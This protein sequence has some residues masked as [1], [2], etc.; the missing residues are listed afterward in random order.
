MYLW[1]KCRKSNSYH[2]SLLRYTAQKKKFSIKDFFSNCDQIRSFLLTWSHLLKKSSFFVQWYSWLVVLNH[3]ADAW[4]HPLEMIK[5]VISVDAWTYAKHQLHNS[6]NS[7]DKVDYLE[8]LL[9]L[10]D[11]PDHTQLKWLSKFVTNDKQN[12]NLLPQPVCEIL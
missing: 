8:S 4:Q 1:I 5:F 3:I 6:T 2:S 9:G 7:W 12:F 11:V 10:P